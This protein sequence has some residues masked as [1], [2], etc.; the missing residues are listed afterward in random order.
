M[1]LCWRVS[2]VCGVERPAAGRTPSRTRSTLPTRVRMRCLRSQPQRSAACRGLSALVAASPRRP[3]TTTV[4]IPIAAGDTVFER[5][6]T[7]ASTR[8]ASG[9]QLSA[10]ASRYGTGVAAITLTNGDATATLLPFQGQQVWDMSVHKGRADEP[11]SLT[12]VSNQRD[13]IHVDPSEAWGLINSYGAF[14]VHCGGNSL[15]IPGTEDN[16]PLHGELPNAQYHDARVVSGEDARGAFIGLEGS[17]EF[18]RFCSQHWVAR[19]SCRLYAGETMLCISMSITNHFHQPMDLMYMGH[20]NFAPVVG[21]QLYYTHECNPEAVRISGSVNGL[22]APTPEYE[23]FLKEL[24]AD[25]SLHNE[26]SAAN[27]KKFNPE[28]IFFLHNYLSDDDGWAHSLQRHPGGDSADLIKHKPAQ[29]NKV[30]R[31]L[32]VDPQHRALGLA[33]PATSEPNGVKAERAKG[34]VRSLAPGSSVLFEFEAGA[35]CGAVSVENSKAQIAEILQ[36]RLGA[37]QGESG[38]SRVGGTQPAKQP[39]KQA[40]KQP[41]RHTLEFLRS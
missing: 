24:E 6:G 12:M 9:A 14:F 33:L 3:I 5:G 19:P 37:G 40:G 22:V 28:I 30:A 11:R 8:A 2:A 18:T 27:L 32:V 4:S 29:L 16:H 20:A 7:V 39:A 31:W 38:Q 41:A 36:G 1:R 35:V 21:S 34:N 17:F 15:G 23:S 25:P 13:P 10:T 26:L